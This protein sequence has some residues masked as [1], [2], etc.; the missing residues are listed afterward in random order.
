[1]QGADDLLLAVGQRAIVEGDVF[2]GDAEG[3]AVTDKREVVG[4]L[5]QE[6]GGDAAPV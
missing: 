1:M 4:G 6:L 3:A 2:G 5:E